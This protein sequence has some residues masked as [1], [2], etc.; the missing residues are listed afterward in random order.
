MSKPD[1]ASLLRQIAVATSPPNSD[2]SNL[3]SDTQ[4]DS[5]LLAAWVSVFG[6]WPNVT[7]PVVLMELTFDITNGS[8]GTSPINIMATSSAAGFTFAGQNHSVTV[9]G[10]SSVNIPTL[11]STTQQVYVSSCTKSSDGTKAI[12]QISYNSDDQTT[13]GLGLRIH[14][15]NRVLQLSAIN[16]V[17]ETGI[18]IRPETTSGA[19]RQALINQAYRFEEPLSSSEK[20]LFSYMESGYIDEQPEVDRISFVGDPIGPDYID[21]D[22]PGAGYI[23]R[24]EYT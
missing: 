7:L 23:P 12:V 17:L 10:T 22:N 6:N 24:S 14:Y 16:N 21:P 13:T 4:T 11:A 2:S 5:F 1:Y 15:D 9:D 20:E 19:A 8:T 3:D 18:F